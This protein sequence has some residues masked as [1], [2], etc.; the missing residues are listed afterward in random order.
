MSINL[1][2]VVNDIQRTVIGYSIES[3]GFYNLDRNINLTRRRLVIKYGAGLTLS[4]VYE[5]AVGQYTIEELV[6]ALNAVA[7]GLFTWALVGER[8][9]ITPNVVVVGEIVVWGEKYSDG[10]ATA[11]SDELATILG[12]PPNIAT[13]IALDPVSTTVPY[14][15]DCGGERVAFLHSYTL[16][17]NKPS[18]DGE[19]LPV[20]FS[21]SFPIS[22]PYGNFNLVY[23]NQYQKAA[24]WW[25]TPHEIREIE[26]RLRTIRGALLDLQGTEWFVTLRLFMQ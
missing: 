17:H 3:V 18:F 5:L 4:L 12:F 26:L 11:A 20:S 1:E 25:D 21:C 2:N 10:G 15:Y 16:A 19:G 7:P 22:V 6:D 8:L 9:V 24:V 23:P 13:P 14:H